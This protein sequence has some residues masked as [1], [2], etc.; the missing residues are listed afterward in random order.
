MNRVTKK[1]ATSRAAVKA[2]ASERTS[3]DCAKGHPPQAA[4]LREST[5]LQALDGGH[6]DAYAT[7]IGD[8]REETEGEQGRPQGLGQ[9]QQGQ[10]EGEAV[11]SVF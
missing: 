6:F 4:R 8:L 11:V 7:K 1:L 9:Q 5:R 10:S 2:E 3:S